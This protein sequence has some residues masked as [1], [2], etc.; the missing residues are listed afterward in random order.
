MIEYRKNS[1]PSNSP[2]A[3]M[4]GKASIKVCKI[5]AIAGTLLTRRKTLPIRRVLAIV[6]KMP[7]RF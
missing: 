1:R 2:K 3:E 6:P 5:I 4:A 7:I